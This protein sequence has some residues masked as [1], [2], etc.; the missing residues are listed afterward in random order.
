MESGKQ[1]L[2]IRQEFI[3]KH[4]LEQNE[5]IE[6]F[7]GTLK[8]EYAWLHEFARFQDAEVVLARAFADCNYCRIHSA[9]WHVTPNEFARKTEN[10]NK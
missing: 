4:T 5:H 10:G 6:S 3:W 2:G 8:M 7:H 1:A 9:L